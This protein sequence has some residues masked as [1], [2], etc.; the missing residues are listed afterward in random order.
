MFDKCR[1]IN[2]LSDHNEEVAIVQHPD[3]RPIMPVCDF[4]TFIINQ[5]TVP[6]QVLLCSLSLLFKRKETGQQLCKQLSSKPEV[7][8][9]P[10]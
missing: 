7:K 2:I 8:P 5:N 3:H 4:C 1:V 10:Q 9:T 6:V